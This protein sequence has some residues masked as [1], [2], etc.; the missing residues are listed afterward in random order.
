MNEF[1]NSISDELTESE[2]EIETDMSEKLDRINSL[3]ENPDK[4]D[5]FY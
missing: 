4:D 2:S 1:K 5:V 3:F